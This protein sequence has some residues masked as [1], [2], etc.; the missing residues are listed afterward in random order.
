MNSGFTNPL[1]LKAIFDCLK[2]YSHEWDTI[3]RGL[4]VK[5]SF[6]QSQEKLGI[7]RTDEQKLEAVLDKWIQSSCSEVSWDHLIKVLEK[8]EFC[9]LADNVKQYLRD[10]SR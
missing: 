2:S 3:G 8:L 9:Q 7:M 4:E 10:N 6:R 5:Y 1:N